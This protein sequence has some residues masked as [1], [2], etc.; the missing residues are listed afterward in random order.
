MTASTSISSADTSTATTL[1]T[2]T[3]TPTDATTTVTPMDTT[4]TATSTETTTVFPGRGKLVCYGN[5]Q[6]KLKITTKGPNRPLSIFLCSN[7]PALLD[8]N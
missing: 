7:Q 8:C 4:T 5:G 2:T 1:I 3:A 6:R